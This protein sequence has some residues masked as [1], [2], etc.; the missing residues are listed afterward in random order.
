MR[1]ALSIALM[2]LL[3]ALP[4]QASAALDRTKIAAAEKAANEFARLARD[5]YKTGKPPRETDPAAK[6]LLDTAFDTAA[7]PAEF[8]DLPR[9][10]QWMANGD[11]IGLVYMLAGT[12]TSNLAQAATNTKTAKLIPE[13]IA[14]FQ[15]EYGRFTDFQ[16]ALWS[17]ALDAIIA[18][19]E[20]APEAERKNPKFLGGFVQIS[21]SVAQSLAGALET[22]TIDGITDEWRRAR[23]TQLN[24]IAPKAAKVIPAP[25][26]EK[27]REFAIDVSNKTENAEIKE[28]VKAF[29][30]GLMK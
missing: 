9:I 20:K 14:S 15:T 17:L 1:V 24:E 3:L 22:F 19:V 28:S 16:I 8:S 25:I 26:R 29:G 7:G 10:N 12:G 23:L 13:N 5:S 21:N 4:Q 18:R 27:L 11:K 6:A 30:D 2:A